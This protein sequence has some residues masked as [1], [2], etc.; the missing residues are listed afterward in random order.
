MNLINLKDLGWNETFEKYFNKLKTKEIFPARIVTAQRELYR[1]YSGF[2]EF[3]AE[4]SG[5]FRFDSTPTSDFPVVGD[6]VVAKLSPEGSMAVIEDILPRFSKLSRKTAGSI[7]EEQVFVSNIDIVFLVNGLDGDYNLRR[8]E[9]YLTLAKDSSV[10]SVV[11]L[12]KTD[13]CSDVRE[14]TAE[15]KAVSRGFPVHTLSALNNRGIENLKKYIKPGTTVAFLGSSGTG[16]STIINRLLGEERLK[17]GAVRKWD[18]SGRH[19]TTRRELI[20]L[21][22]GGI[23]ID[24]PGL[25]ELQV[26]ANEDTLDNTFSD[27][28]EFAGK[29]RFRNCSHADE[30]DCAVRS[31]IEKGG[32]SSERFQ[33]YIKLNREIRSLATRKEKAK[34]RNE[35][36]ITEKKISRLSKQ[37]KKH[38]RK[39]E[40]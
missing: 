22:G 35:K 39:Y 29:C 19:V 28:K 8:I 1:I 10:K 12:N 4:I 30:P 31:A 36:I 32:L 6:W 20:I 18:S 15:V 13:V 40:L 38:K 25:R 27:I 3:D 34:S 9:R 24:N 14:K 23:V 37:I 17:V 21:P 2:G 5:K 7:T 11:L 16:K 26:W 33:S